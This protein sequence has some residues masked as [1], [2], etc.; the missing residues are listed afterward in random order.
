MLNIVRVPAIITISHSNKNTLQTVL[1]EVISNK[2]QICVY[3]AQWFNGLYLLLNYIQ[4][5]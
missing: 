5:L 2:K 3:K 4:S 1:T